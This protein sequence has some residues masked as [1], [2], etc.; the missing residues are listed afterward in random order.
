MTKNKWIKTIKKNCEE[1][2][3]YRPAFDPVIDSLADLLAIRDEA[4]KHYDGSPIVE[5]TNSH[6]ETNLAKNPALLIV[7]RYEEI[8]LKYWVQLGLTPAGLKKIN[9]AAMQNRGGNALLDALRELDD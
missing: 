5:H 8:A 2:G 9:D 7:E 3:T 1:V 6:G 4:M